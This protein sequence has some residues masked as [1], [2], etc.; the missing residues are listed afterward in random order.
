MHLEIA[1][2]RRS[3]DVADDVKD[4]ENMLKKYTN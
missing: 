1:N 3:T 2:L 4:F